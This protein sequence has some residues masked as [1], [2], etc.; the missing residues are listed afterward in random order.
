MAEEFP[1]HVAWAMKPNGRRFSMGVLLDGLADR[2]F[3]ERILAGN[4]IK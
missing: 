3:A 4:P 2:E 1:K